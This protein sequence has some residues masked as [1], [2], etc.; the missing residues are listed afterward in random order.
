MYAAG[1]ATRV[2]QAYA[3][4]EGLKSYMRELARGQG[5]SDVGPDMVEVRLR[6][7]AV[8][9]GFLRDA[10]SMKRTAAGDVL[11]LDG[12]REFV[13]GKLVWRWHFSYTAGPAGREY[14]H[15]AELQVAA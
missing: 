15:A 3:D 14:R 1:Q 6:L 5:G 12:D 10:V 2:W 7:S 11:I 13:C 4:V 8:Q 9:H